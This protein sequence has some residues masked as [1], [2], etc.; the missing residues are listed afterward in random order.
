MGTVHVYF[1]RAFSIQGIDGNDTLTVSAAPRV[2]SLAAY[3]IAL[4]GNV[5]PSTH[6]HELIRLQSNTRTTRIRVLAYS[7]VRRGSKALSNGIS[8][9]RVSNNATRRSNE[10]EELM[11][12]EAEICAM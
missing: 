10:K 1:L 8:A 2:S 5:D 3:F 9:R 7:R 6:T 12:T 11:M 4:E